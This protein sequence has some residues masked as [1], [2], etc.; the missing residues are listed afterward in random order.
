MVQTYFA[1]AKAE[2][3]SLRAEARMS[4]VEKLLISLNLPT[5]P[6]ID[7]LWSEEAEK[8]IALIVDI[9]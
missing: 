4:L 8:R 9:I 1:M 2:A 6:E 5:H 3:L 7:R